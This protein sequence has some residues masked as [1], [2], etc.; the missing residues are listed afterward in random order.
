MKKLSVVL[1]VIT[2][3]LSFGNDMENSEFRITELKALMRSTFRELYYFNDIK[4]MKEKED[5]LFGS[6]NRKSPISFK[7]NNID[8]KSFGKVNMLPHKQM[9]KVS[10]IKES[11]KIYIDI[12]TKNNVYIPIYAILLIQA[13]ITGALGK[14]SRKGFGSFIIESMLLNG[15]DEY[16]DLLIG[17]P[18]DILEN[19]N[20]FILDKDLKDLGEYILGINKD[21]V[22]NEIVINKLSS[23]LDYPY[24]KK[25]SFIKIC[26]KEYMGLIKKISQL[27]HDR[28][29]K[30]DNK[31]GNEED[32]TDGIEN[33]QEIKR[34]IL[35]NCKGEKCGMKRFASPVSISFWE[36]SDEKYM[37]IKE[38]NY[39]YILQKL[40]IRNDKSL[41]ANDEYV[42]KYI[43][44]LK[45]IGGND[46][47]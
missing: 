42:Q 34:T 9:P 17:K 45:D 28:L 7:L 26:D 13:S 16:K 8:K 33:N 21:G 35:G 19:C 30:K 11:S 27:T 44:E 46:K 2:P 32:F 5:K 41:K 20:K 24:V 22:N 47:K 29:R 40:N 6:V 14:R 1:K 18:E 25:I 12:I 43:K 37:V 38:L 4:D 10:C 15:E 23:N 39:N 36:N 3:M 31:K